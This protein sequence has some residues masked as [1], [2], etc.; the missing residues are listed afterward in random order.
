MLRCQRS[1]VGQEGGLQ[2]LRRRW[3]VLLGESQHAEDH[4]RALRV[5]VAAPQLLRNAVQPAIA[6]APVARVCLRTASKLANQRVIT[7]QV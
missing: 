7:A 2:H 4:V 3:P 5:D 1:S 6:A